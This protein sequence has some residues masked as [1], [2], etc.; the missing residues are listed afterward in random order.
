MVIVAAPE[1]AEAV[2]AALEAAGERPFAIGAVTA[3]QGVRYRGTL[4]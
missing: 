2:A 3:G 1:R 4:R